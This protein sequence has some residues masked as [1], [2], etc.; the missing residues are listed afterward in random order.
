VPRVQYWKKLKK[1]INA[2]RMG[3]QV[4]KSMYELPIWKQ[5]S[6][7]LGSD[8]KGRTRILVDREKDAIIGRKVC[9]GVGSDLNGG[10]GE[11]L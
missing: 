11:L 2:G 7:V 3:I 10:T 1:V 5:R 9:D 4:G 6:I 8:S